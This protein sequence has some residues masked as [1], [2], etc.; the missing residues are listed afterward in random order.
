MDVKV[1]DEHTWFSGLLYWFDIVQSNLSKTHENLAGG[2]HLIKTLQSYLTT[3]SQ[4]HLD[5]ETS[6][7]LEEASL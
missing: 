7:F 3:I 5:P 2:V 4:I 6:S 1:L